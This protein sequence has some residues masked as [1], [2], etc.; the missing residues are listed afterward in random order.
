MKLSLR[1]GHAEPNRT[2]NWWQPVQN[3]PY[4]VLHKNRKWEFAIYDEDPSKQVDYICHF[5]EIHPHNSLWSN[6]DYKNID[7][8]FDDG[9]GGPC[10]CGSA[11]T[12]FP[13]I[14]MFFCPKWSKI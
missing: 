13:Q 8:L 2:V 3:F 14:H 12:S 5:K 7:H 10:Q 6:T 4:L 9:F 1:F 11:Y